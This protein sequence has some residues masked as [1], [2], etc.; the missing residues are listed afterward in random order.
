MTI[1]FFPMAELLRDAR[2]EIDEAFDRVISSGHLILGQE[3]GAFEHE[4]AAYCGAA[5]CIGVGNGLDA[6]AIALWAQGIGPGDEVIVPG[7]TFI[8]SWLA[9]SRTGAVPVGADV[10]PHSFNL[11]PASIEAAIT[12]RTA[13]IMPVHLYGNPAAMDEIN[14]V[15]APHGLFLLE[16]A[17]QAHGARYWARRA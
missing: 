5:H 16:D 4:F 3:V 13:A 8:A 12:P 15:A 14:R 2:R 1:E 11:A 10:E 6:L 9:I 7:H 17:A